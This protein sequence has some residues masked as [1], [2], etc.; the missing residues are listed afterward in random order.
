MTKTEY[1]GARYVPV[2]ADPPEWTNAREYEPLTVV[3]YQGNSFTSKQFVP[4]N[5]D[6]LNRD[7]WVMSSNYNAQTGILDQKIDNEILARQNADLV[8]NN[9]V[10]SIKEI[11]PDYEFSDENTVKD[12]IDNQTKFAKMIEDYS[13]SDYIF[14]SEYVAQYPNSDDDALDAAI[15][16]ALANPRLTTLVIDKTLHIYRSHT[17]ATK[18]NSLNISIKSF[19][20]NPI[21]TPA[22]YRSMD[23]PLDIFDFVVH[24]NNIV[25][26]AFNTTIDSEIQT[27]LDSFAYIDNISMFNDTTIDDRFRAANSNVNAIYY[28]Y[29]TLIVDGLMTYGFNK[30]LFAPA[31]RPTGENYCDFCQFKNIRIAYPQGTAIKSMHNDNGLYS[32]INIGYFNRDING[33]LIDIHKDSNSILENIFIKCSE[34]AHDTTDGAAIRIRDSV[35]N[36]NSIAFEMNQFDYMF[37]INNSNVAINGLFNKFK[38]G[39]IATMENCRVTLQNMRFSQISEFSAAQAFYGNIN[40]SVDI[41]N[42]PVITLNGLTT[43][44]YAFCSGAGGGGMYNYTNSSII[45]AIVTSSGASIRN[46]K[47]NVIGLFTAEVNGRNIVLTCPS[48][49]LN[50]IYAPRYRVTAGDGTQIST[51]SA[52]GNT[53]TIQCDRDVSTISGSVYIWIEFEY[54]KFTA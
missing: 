46:F 3:L 25:V 1:I 33:P 49:V 43:Y 52:S 41:I 45:R 7:Y 9:E 36:A 10:D 26:L 24:G 19:K 28:H 29:M 5:I 44:T 32:C 47:N 31:Q 35:V 23:I 54:T 16:A 4:A 13:L 37:D 22:K 6:I 42:Q 51:I 14:V 2:F 18:A 39:K 15:A 30:T 53:L 17:I 27:N 34:N 12:Y 50:V 48:T 8:I 40:T 21:L 20:P 38:Q 11:I